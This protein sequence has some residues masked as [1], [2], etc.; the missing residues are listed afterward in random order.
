MSKKFNN[1]RNKYSNQ[2][3]KQQRAAASP[4]SN[5][6][7]DAASIHYAL[8]TGA[9][10]DFTGTG[11]SRS[12]SDYAIPGVMAV[13]LV[14]TIGVAQ[15]PT[16]PINIAATQVDSF[17]RHANSGSRN[18]GSGDIMQYLLAMGSVYSFITHLRRIYATAQLFT[19]GNKYYPNT[20]LAAMGVNPADVYSNMATFRMGIRMIITKAAQFA[21]PL[22]MTFF[23]EQENLF[24][25]VYVESPNSIKDQLY[26]FVPAGFYKMNWKKASLEFVR[27]PKSEASI[28]YAAPELYT[29]Q[30]LLDFG[31]L[32]I[33]TIL[34][35]DDLGTMNGDI[36]KAY[37][38]ALK[39]LVMLDDNEQL[40]L[41]YDPL[42]LEQIQN[43]GIVTNVDWSTLDIESTYNEGEGLTGMSQL[44]CLPRTETA[45][46]L[47]NTP[48]ELTASDSIFHYYDVCNVT[49]LRKSRL[50]STEL[51]NPGPGETMVITRLAPVV[52]QTE[53]VYSD[54]PASGSHIPIPEYAPGSSVIFSGTKFVSNIRVFTKQF[55]MM[56]FSRKLPGV[57]N[58]GSVS[59]DYA[60]D[61]IP[62]IHL[63]RLRTLD[64][65]PQ[66]GMPKYES[67]FATLMIALVSPFK[68]RPALI[69]GTWTGR[70][71]G[72]GRFNTA[73]PIF[74]VQKID[75]NA[76]VST[77][78]LQNM[79]TADI[80]TQF[81][82][83]VIGQLSTRK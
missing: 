77:A 65:N 28:N 10:L 42:V 80:L 83:P 71:D 53:E 41:V 52:L 33:D 7:K 20:L 21:V 30:E 15:S 43:C 37:G 34:G 64:D 36:Q 56:E 78:D 38:D 54:I 55:I 22:G 8:P 16:D 3:N 5:I 2:P 18:Y 27:Y 61:I 46:P 44:F 19:Y 29:V 6:I 48:A 9:N 32:L 79:H 45:W 60:V 13:E 11:M 14:P 1:K 49:E 12:T 82:A 81:S 70:N 59:G 74:R 72:A 31:N 75:T 62:T 73:K 17:V 23:D 4:T 57:W 69:F 24:R 25:D 26:L 67:C 50:I 66:N 51:E 35:N 63:E 39:K 76:L 68:Y 58:Y 40:N 47:V